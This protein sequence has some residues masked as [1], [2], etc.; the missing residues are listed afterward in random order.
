MIKKTRHFVLFNLYSN[1]VHIFLLFTPKVQ[2]V[3]CREMTKVHRPA[4]CVWT[5]QNPD[6]SWMQ[7]SQKRKHI[8]FH[9]R[10]C[11]SVLCWVWLKSR[12]SVGKWNLHYCT[13]YLLQLF[14]ILITAYTPLKF[15]PFSVPH[16]THCLDNSI[17]LNS[18][19]HFSHS[20]QLQCTPST[21]FYSA[22]SSFMRHITFYSRHAHSALRHFNYPSLH[23]SF[24]FHILLH[25]DIK[26][27]FPRSSPI[28]TLF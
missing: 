24:Y 27:S 22:H 1:I 18:Y 15:P 5:S 4:I 6:P 26:C 2:L 17:K 7:V 10:S 25:E 9:I 3:V 20:I 14:R 12:R 8:P 13:M 21:Y 23:F 28:F 11:Y 16:H 19:I